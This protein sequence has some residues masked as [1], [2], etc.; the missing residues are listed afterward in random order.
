MTEFNERVPDA[1]PRTVQAEGGSRLVDD[2]PYLARLNLSIV[3]GNVCECG[4]VHTISSV[5]THAL[6][7][8]TWERTIAAGERVR[9]TD[10]L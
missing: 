1:P 9:V 3:Q 6:I 8:S 2:D 7:S 5:C 4:E 10:R